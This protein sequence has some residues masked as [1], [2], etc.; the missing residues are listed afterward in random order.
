MNIEQ[1]QQHF[2]RTYERRNRIFMVNGLFGRIM[3]LNLAIGDLQEAIRKEFSKE[4]I[5]TALARVVARIFCVAN[6]FIN[7]QLSQAMV[8]KYPKKHCS[9]CQST[10]CQ[11]PEKRPE[12]KLEESILPEQENWDLNQWG[13]HLNTLY[14]QRNILR[15]IEYIIN[16]LSKEI[17]E[18]ISLCMGIPNTRS[19]IKTI[20]LD[21][22]LELSDAIA[23]TIAIANYLE[24]DLEKAVTDRYG[25][26]CSTCGQEECGCTHFDIRPQKWSK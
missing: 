5:A 21:F 20:E 8:Q 23:W 7:L 24:I 18:L 9:Y 4:I 10:P 14:G 13:S 16:R 26:G 15:G 6:Y 12:P 2:C 22:A 17:S 3:F 25:N 11:C 1:L 19:D